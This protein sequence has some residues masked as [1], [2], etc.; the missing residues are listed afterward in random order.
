MINFADVENENVK[1]I[2]HSTS[3]IIEININEGDESNNIML[4]YEQW[5]NILVCI[6]KISTIDE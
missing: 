4:D 5:H 2:H 1:I 6:Y 3:S